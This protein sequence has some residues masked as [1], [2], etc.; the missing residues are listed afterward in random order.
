MNA[1][2]TMN[3]NRAAVDIDESSKS[4]MTIMTLP[5][6]LRDF[7]YEGV[8]GTKYRFRAYQISDGV[9]HFSEPPLSHETFSDSSTP[10]SNNPATGHLRF[11]NRGVYTYKSGEVPYKYPFPPRPSL[12][13]LQA[14][15]RVRQEALQVLYQKGTLLFVLNH[16]SQSF[17][18]NS[19]SHQLLKNF[20]NVEIFLD[21][22]S[23]FT[24]SPEA[25]EEKRAIRVTMGLIKRTANSA[26]AASTCMLST[27]YRYDN[28]I[29]ESYFFMYLLGTAGKLRVFKKVV[30]RFGNRFKT[31]EDHTRSSTELAAERASSDEWAVDIYKQISRTK[32]F[33]CLGP[34]KEN[35]DSEGFYCLVYHPRDHA[36]RGDSS[37]NSGSG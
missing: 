26:G 24:H 12:S 1:N 30:L 21:L 2:A 19:Q 16:P 13:I 11:V 3:M 35:Y 10:S 22:A 4:A 36:A 37:S 6:E 8:V 25:R 28:E 15:T 20:N 32:E 14:S 18:F 7:I 5:P 27:Y 9:P 29:F 34:C 31:A 33:S 23:M 17:R